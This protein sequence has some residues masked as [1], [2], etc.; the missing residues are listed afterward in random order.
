MRINTPVTQT[1]HLLV[2]GM[3]IVSTTDLRGNIISV[4]PYFIQVSGYSEQELIGAPQNILRHPDMPAEAFADMWATIKDGIPWSGVVKN[5]C[6]NGDFYWVNARVTPVIDN[7]SMVG[8]MSIRT[9]P[10]RAQVDQASDLYQ[11]FKSGNPL[12]L[13]LQNGKV[14]K[15]AQL[16][17]FAK[18]RRPPSWRA[19]ARALQWL[20]SITIARKFGFVIASAMLGIALLSLFFLASERTMLLKER[21]AGVRQ[22]V[23]TAHGVLR[24]YQALAAGGKLGDGEARAA[25]LGMLK[26]MRYDGQEYF[27]V[28]DLDARMVMHPV[29]PELD[30]KDLSGLADANGKHLFSEFARVVKADGAGFVSYLWPKPGSERPVQ[31]ISYVQGF[32]PWGWVVGSGVYVDTV[33][34]TMHSRLLQYALGALLLAAVLLTICLFFS[35][36]LQRQLGGEPEYVSGVVRAIAGGD[37]AVPILT[38]PGD[39]SSLLSSTRNMRD[40][41]ASLVGQVRAG[42][43]TVASASSQIASGNLDLSARTEQQASALQQTA[44]SMAQLTVTVKQNGEHARQ[45]DAL[46]CSASAVAQQGGALVSE[47]VATMGAISESSHKIV[48]IIGVIDGIAFQTNILALNAAV[49]AAR[50]G[51]QG[52]GFAVVATEVRNLAQRSAAA[53]REVKTLIDASVES[54][55]SGGELVSQAGSTM[56]EIVSSVGRVTEIMGEITRASAAQ[57]SGIEHINQAIGEMD[58]VTQ[59]NAALVEEAAATAGTLHDQ[60]ANLEQLVNV[61]KLNNRGLLAPAAKPL[62]KRAAPAPACRRLY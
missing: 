42:T 59:Q 8:Y 27:W 43:Y 13:A 52:R 51:E 28:N 22:A 44:S 49:E 7:E 50:A 11:N 24:H 20:Q 40:S 46:V 26:S 19:G 57:E 9:K 17:K 23:E 10:S 33:D 41:L 60:A 55:A 3:S 21:E 37:L 45:A 2:D 31:K 4:N 53:A 61:F 34:A 48:D 54:V 58:Q 15:A 30:G 5:R 56:Q 1:E 32:A 16:A 14:L 29:K 6:K 36:G 62:P 39:Q 47:V 18:R 25:A 38:A 12:G 35:R